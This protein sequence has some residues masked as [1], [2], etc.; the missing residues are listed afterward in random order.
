MTRPLVSAWPMAIL[1]LAGVSAVFAA[2]ENLLVNPTFEGELGSEASGW[3]VRAWESDQVEITVDVQVDHDGAPAVRIAQPLPVYSCLSQ[4]FD[5]QPRT[6]YAAQVWARGE[7]LLSTGGGLRLFIGNE[8][9][10]TVTA[11]RFQDHWAG[12]GW[13]RLTCVFNSA[14]RERM[15][16]VLMLHNASGVA[17]FADPAVREVTPAEAAELTGRAHGWGFASAE[18]ETGFAYFGRPVAHVTPAFPSPVWFS[19]KM[20]FADPVAAQPAI[21]LELPA[22]VEVAGAYREWQIASEPTEGGTRCR[23]SGTV[24]Y[25]PTYLIT[26]R[27]PG[28]RGEGRLWLEWQGGRQEQ[29]F[30]FEVASVEMPHARRPQRMICGLSGPPITGFPGDFIACATQMGFNAVNL[31][32]TAWGDPPSETLSRAVRDY[33]AAGFAVSNDYSPYCYPDYRK[34]LAEIEDAQACTIDGTRVPSIPCPSYRGEAWQYEGANIARFV[35]VGLSWCH[36]DEE[37]WNGQGICFCPRCLAQWESYRAEHYPDLPDTPPTEFEAKP[38]EHPALHAAWIRF[39]CSLVTDS[40]LG[41]RQM[42]FDAIEEAGVRSSPQPWL[43]SWLALSTE[44]D[45][46]YFYLHDPADLTRALDHQVPMIYDTAAVVREELLPIVEAAGGERVLVGLTLG[47]PGNGRQVF[48]PEQTRASI[49]EGA[50]A[51][52]LGYVLWTYH[53]GDAGTLAAVAGTNDLLARIEDIL[54]DGARTRRL[55]VLEGDALVTAYELGDEIVAYVRGGRSA[56]LGVAGSASWRV[57]DADS[58]EALADVTP[59]VR[60]FPVTLDPIAGRVLRLT[61]GAPR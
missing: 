53:R 16:V 19:A 58:G 4:A 44:P 32:G 17:W 7:D 41:W 45:D 24:E 27:A 61:R 2:G 60:E 1:A 21:V 42:L 36:M 46:M 15:T 39:K 40:F 29:P 20:D 18:P 37:V 26:T 49:L 13:R 14:D 11:T 47:E 50:F 8:R 10:N 5:V 9:G 33:V 35:L 12:A 38:A 22:D 30:V 6:I 54:L 59:D 3:S 31:W 56:C 28:W 48:P 25:C 57:A 43:D 52:C 23:L 34:M 51:P 55:S